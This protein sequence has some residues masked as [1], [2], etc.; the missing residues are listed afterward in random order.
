MTLRVPF[1]GILVLGLAAWP[2]AAQTVRFNVTGTVVDTSGSALPQ[3]TVVA[4]TRADSVL[5]KFATSQNTG[6]FT[7]RRMTPGS[8]ILQI[9]FVGYQT[10]RHDFD[11]TDSDVEIGLLTMQELTA[12]LDELVVSADHIPFVV[13]RDTLEYN[14]NAFTTR[15]GDV[16]EDLLRRLPGIDVEPDGTIKAQ[17]EE[18]ENVLVDGK[19]FFANTPTV[20]TKNLPADAVDRVQVYDKASD[21]AEFSGIDDGEEEKTIDLLL[22]DGAKRGVLGSLEGGLGGEQSP[23]GRYRTRV[24]LHRF[25]PVLQSSLIG[26][27][28][29][30]GQSGFGVGDL[31]SMIQSGAGMMMMSS[32]ILSNVNFGGEASGGFSESVNAGLNLSRD[33]G[34]RTYLRGSYFL[35]SLDQV[36]DSYAQRHE[37]AGQEAS[38]RW[39]QNGLSDTQTLGH[40]INLNGQLQISPGHEIRLRSSLSIHLTN[41]LSTS[42]QQTW[43]AQH[44]LRNDASR[45]YD[46]RNYNTNGNSSL[47][48]R[49]KISEAGRTLV[50][51]GELRLTDADQTAELFSRTSLAASGNVM[52]WQEL[53]QEQERYGRSNTTEQRISLTEPLSRAAS[54]ELFGEHTLTRSKEDKQFYNV[55]GGARE[56]DFRLSNA[57]E[58]TYRYWRG[59]S[60]FSWKGSE[61][62][63]TL[64]LNLQRS[65]LDGTAETTVPDVKAGFTHVLPHVYYERTLGDN[66]NID[67]RYRSS[68]REPSLRELQP[69]TDNEDPLRI[70]IGNPALTPETSHSLTAKFL[71]FDQWTQISIMAF[72]ESRYNHNQIVPSRSIDENFRQVI[73]AVNSTGGWTHSGT[74][75][76]RAPIRPLRVAITLDNRLT[77]STGME[78]IN[79]QQNDNSLLRN[80]ASLRI[81]NRNQDILELDATARM[82]YNRVAYSLNQSLGREYINM[83]YSGRFA[84]HLTYDWTLEADARYRTYDDGVFG[85]AQNMMLMNLSLSKLLMN[86]R[87]SLEFGVYDLLNQNL[88]VHFSNTATYVQEQRIETL[89]RYMML[90]A[91]WKLNSVRG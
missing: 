16:V 20:A 62:R 12:E 31:V 53:Q 86:E 24:N 87:V 17:G 50:A 28:S 18:V 54:L 71:S 75:N 8:Y 19:E 37:L 60:Q 7:L 59:G 81:R 91:S 48:W 56:R 49:R 29:N 11:I 36:Q 33:F 15:P 83:E 73:S 23:V 82:T 55:S 3:A 61:D 21:Q 72:T 35:N 45:N 84:W 6:Q 5:T 63:F 65:A 9:T 2:A 52:T 46:T 78:F 89:G 30:T 39:N 43:N 26:N 67:I 66:R 25:S 32:G 90:R 76:F 40:V 69:Y 4:L 77:W 22:K 47:T 88:G 74:V 70:Y 10:I 85:S 38:A 41:A 42:A 64:G 79:D 51:R 13:K 27:A 57:F 58:R 1:F 14:A 68:T 34:K 80:S 44:V